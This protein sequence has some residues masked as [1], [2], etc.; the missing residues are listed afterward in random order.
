VL[1]Y[2]GFREG[3]LGIQNRGKFELKISNWW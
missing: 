2:K 3:I 1:I